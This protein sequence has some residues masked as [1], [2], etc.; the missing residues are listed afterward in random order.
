MRT[1]PQ[2][3]P[4]SE[5]DGKEISGDTQVIRRLEITVE[6]RVCSIEI[7]GPA[8]LQHGTCCPVC[9]VDF[10]QRIMHALRPR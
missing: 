4:P 9:G 2:N 10:T 8:Q 6:R 1:T 3:L 7:H 5:A